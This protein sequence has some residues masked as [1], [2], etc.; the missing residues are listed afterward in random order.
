VPPLERCVQLTTCT[1]QL[2]TRVDFL[3]DLIL[4]TEP[5][6]GTYVRTGRVQGT[7]C[8]LASDVVGAVLYR[9]YAKC[10]KEGINLFANAI[11]V[12]LF[13]LPAAGRIGMKPEPSKH[14]RPSYPVHFAYLSATA[15]ATGSRL[16]S[17]VHF[18]SFY[19]IFYLSFILFCYLI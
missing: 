10:R 12:S 16:R 17:T 6:P 15:C 8:L 9:Q 19:F 11:I 7:L 4:C 3:V 2:T 18:I 14:L 1:P 5:V 13:A